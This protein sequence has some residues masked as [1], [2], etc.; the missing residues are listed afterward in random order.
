MGPVFLEVVANE[1]AAVAV[2][3]RDQFLAS[4]SDLPMDFR[5][6]IFSSVGA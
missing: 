1:V 2:Y 6:R 3:F 4:F 5:R